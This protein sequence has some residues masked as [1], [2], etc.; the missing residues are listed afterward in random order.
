MGRYIP[1]DIETKWQSKWAQ[2]GLYDIDLATATNKHYVLGEFAYPSGDLHMGHWFM[3]TGA[4]IY[5]RLR[6]MQGYQVFFP[7]GFDAFGLPAENAAIKRGIHPKDWTM[8]NIEAMKRQFSTMGASFSFK[9]EVITCLPQYYKW[10]Q[11]IFLKMYEKG[12]AYRGKYLSNWCPNCQ[13]VLANEGVTDGKCWRCGTEV[14]QK[15]IAQW[16]FRITDYAD[17][18]LWNNPPQAD[19]PKSVIEAQNN[20]IGRSEGLVI[21]FPILGT[22]GPN[23][24]SVEISASE[25]YIEVFTTRPDTLCGVSFV[26]V[27]PEHVLIAEILKDDSYPIDDNALENVRAY[28]KDASKKSEMQRKENKV[29]TGVFTGIFVE[30]PLNKQK[31]PVW[32]ADYVLPGYGTGA[33]MGV[34]AHDTRD[35][36]FA[37]AFDLP[38][39]QVITA[40]N[41]DNPVVLPYE[42]NGIL[43]N[44]GD[45]DGLDSSTATVKISKYIE[46]EQSGYVKTNYHLHDWSISRQRYWGTPIPIVYC[47]DCGTVPVPEADLPIELPYEVEY[48]P[49][50]KPPLA[51]AEEWM[52]APC[53]QCGKPALREAETMDTF[54]D[55]SWYFMRYL[56]PDL[57]NSPF[58]I[59]LAKTIAP[60][61]VYFGGS[62]HTLG[63]TMYARFFTKF[64]KDLGLINFDEFASK[65]IGHGVV[66]GPDGARMS[67]SKGNVVNPDTEVQKYGADAVRIYLAFFMP[68]EA[69]GPWI[70]D[71]II[72]PY[73]F[74]ERVWDLQKKAS[75]EAV[76]GPDDLRI[77]HKTIRKVGEDIADIKFNTAVAA[78]MEWL[79]ALS[80]RPQIADEEY[81]TLLLLLAPFAPH[82]TEEL[83]LIMGHEYSIHTKDWPQYDTKYLEQSETLLVVQVN[84]KVRDQILISKD[85]EGDSKVVEEKVL[86]SPKL[87]AFL[88]GTTIKKII[89][90]P[91]KIFSIVI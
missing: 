51:T 63:H 12:I 23:D 52:K 11:W 35:F 57:E 88:G 18:L 33:V 82:M 67:K 21:K 47:D 24:Q 45:Y 58:D 1:K 34:P 46:S 42:G 44:S 68:Y 32:V 25:E 71:R 22:K 43:I 90:V 5:A 66:L 50:G 84:G 91:G 40:S 59:E 17:K 7:N 6:R 56:S 60:V 85:I 64:F 61:D 53:P 78:L 15:E 38:I 27:N 55:S 62:E 70:S 73:H 9:N 26:V 87:Q 31:V 16:F 81:K 54:V 19:W 49:Q 77:M 80:R 69:T 10:N 29:K 65:R 8:S 14:I 74:L 2:D 89:Y 36:E 83:W 75:Q 37:K 76:V 72:G 86:T 39:T 48:A 20:W 28:V 41:E 3:F 13:T 79:N 30:N 4:D